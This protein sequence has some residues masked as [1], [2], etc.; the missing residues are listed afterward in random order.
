MLTK[1]E[2]DIMKNV[3]EKV[4]IIFN[5]L[6]IMYKIISNEMRHFHEKS[7]IKL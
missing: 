6:I 7:L 2:R 3:I 5:L 4:Q 1:V